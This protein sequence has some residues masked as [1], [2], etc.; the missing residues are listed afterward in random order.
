MAKRHTL[1]I[2]IGDEM[3]K[4]GINMYDFINRDETFSDN[5]YLT[6]FC[7]SETTIDQQ[8][9]TTIAKIGENGIEGSEKLSK[10]WFINTFNKTHNVE[11]Q[12]PFQDMYMCLYLPLFN[13]KYVAQARQI[14]AMANN[15]D[16]NIQYC[17]DLYGLSDDLAKTISLEGDSNKHQEIQ[18]KTLKDLISI[19]KNNEIHRLIVMKSINEENLSLNFD[20]N[21]LSYI[22][23]E[24]ACLTSDNFYALYPSSEFTQPE[25]TTF[26]LSAILFERKMFVEYL[27]HKAYIHILERE[28]VNDTKVDSGKVTH[29]ASEKLKNAENLFDKF[30][31]REVLP[32][33]SNKNLSDNERSTTINEK[34]TEWL[35]KE[36][37]GVT[38]L[39]H[40][41]ITSLPEK[42]A[43]MAQLLGYDDEL[44]EGAQLN[45]DHPIVDDY[46]AKPIEEYIDEDN[47]NVTIEGEGDEAVGVGG[48]LPYSNESLGKNEFM[49]PKVKEVSNRI[50]QRTATIRCYQER[51][52]ELEKLIS[53]TDAAEGVLTNEGFRYKGVVYRTIDKIDPKPLEEDYEPAE[54]IKAAESIDMRSGFAAIRSQGQIGACTTFASSSA[55]EYMIGDCTED[56]RLSPRFIYYNVVKRDENGNPIDKGS[57]YYDVLH[58]LA[59]KG[60][61]YEQYAPYDEQK[62]WEKPSAEAEEDAKNHRAIVSKNVKV[63]H[64]YIKKALT[65]GYP[66]CISLRLFDGFGSNSG[67]FIFRPTE[68]EISN[69]EEH[70]HAM[71]IVGYSK[72]AP[73][74]IVRNSWGTDFGDKGYCYVPF[75][76]IEDQ[77]ICRAAYII[78]ETN[79]NSKRVK[80]AKKRLT[81]EFNRSDHNIEQALLRIELEAENSKLESDVLLRE[82]LLARHKNTVIRLTNPSARETI[83]NGGI[84]RRQEQI[85]ELKQRYNNLLDG[86]RARMLERRRRFN[87]FSYICLGLTLALAVVWRIKCFLH[88]S[89]A[90]IFDPEQILNLPKWAQSIL[91]NNPNKVFYVPLWV[92]FVTVLCVVGLVLL[93]ITVKRK[94]SKLKKAIREEEESLKHDSDVNGIVNNKRDCLD[95]LLY[96][97]MVGTIIIANILIMICMALVRVGIWPTHIQFFSTAP[98]WLTWINLIITAIIVCI[99]VPFLIMRYITLKKELDE[100]LENLSIQIGSKTRDLE[101]YPY[102]MYTAGRIIEEVSRMRNQIEG[103]YLKMKSYLDNLIIWLEE[104]REKAGQGLYSYRAPFESIIKED[105]LDRYFEENKE[106]I[107]KDVKLY[108]AID[109]FEVGEVG[110]TEFK[111]KTLRNMIE[112][113]ILNPLNDFTMYDYLIL[114]QQYQYLPEC[115]DMNA[116]MQHMEKA[117]APFAPCNIGGV[118]T[119]SPIKTVLLADRGDNDWRRKILSHFTLAPSTDTIDNKN[120]FVLVS[121]R[122]MTLE[123]LC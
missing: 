121:K 53:D 59:E 41:P 62:I 38:A 89:S 30:F 14:V 34:L 118:Q 106:T 11:N 100:E 29:I 47:K 65:E 12:D 112:D 22:L 98:V 35:E 21:T 74:Y 73:V 58:F 87:I 108:E 43:T 54:G 32:L 78:T 7:T 96:N 119:T 66:V 117:G 42:K 37:N 90:L 56:T 75:S 113:V 109:K 25:V 104:E 17:I 18:D 116:L 70:W 1:H 85:D 82:E 105:V 101:K 13:E 114:K 60:T 2:L 26:G 28:E 77:R 86:E 16:K 107:T 99:T 95:L 4:L 50:K 102:R 72:E 115:G 31:E 20:F 55:L 48:E 27:L 51:I 8:T 93:F 24:F 91:G 111:T 80:T 110:V 92:Y 3:S 69:P 103:K 94:R 44:L 61:C 83:T 120:V 46:Y 15:C 68:E 79:N 67:G 19:E 123:E 122:E 10:E 71:V 5:D 9:E 49:L 40:D 23:A 6:L 84:K 33:L 63:D 97:T 45:T 88:T 39:L 52:D 64:E 81:I 57:S 76:Y 36:T